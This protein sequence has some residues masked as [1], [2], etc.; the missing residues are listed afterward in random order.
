M[1]FNS[2]SGNEPRSPPRTQRNLFCGFAGLAPFAVQE[3]IIRNSS[4][5]L[6]EHTGSGI[7]IPHPKSKPSYSIPDMPRNPLIHP[8]I[9]NV[10][11]AY[12][13]SIRSQDRDYPIQRAYSQIKESSLEIAPITAE[14][15]HGKSRFFQN[16]FEPVGIH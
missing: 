7:G 2:C 14:Y 13:K 9:N 1:V 3:C 5:Y 12:C 10:I 16:R 15:L 4:S 8:R 11:G 6:R